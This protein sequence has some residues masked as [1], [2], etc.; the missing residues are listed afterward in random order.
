MTIIIPLFNVSDSN[1]SLDNISKAIKKKGFNKCLKKY[2]IRKCNRALEKL[3]FD[4]LFSD[5]RRTS[6]FGD[7]STIVGISWN[8]GP[9]GPWALGCEFKGNDLSKVRSKGEECSGKCKE[10]DGCTHYNWTKFNGG[11]CWMKRGSATQSDA[12]KSLSGNVCGFLSKEISWNDGGDGPWAMG[13]EFKGNDLSNVRSKGE[14]CSGRCKSTKGC[15]HYNW[16]NENGGTC[17]MKQGSIS[18]SNA[19]NSL[20]NNVCGILNMEISWNDGPDGPW[21][22][23]CDFNGNDLSNVRSE[24]EECSGKCKL[25]KG[26]THYTW[27]NFNDGTCWMKQGSI[28]Q[29]NAFKAE[30]E[31]N[32]VCGILDTNN[33]SIKWRDGPDGQEAFK[34]NFSGNDLSNVE[35][36]DYECSGECIATKGCTHYTWNNENGGTCRMKKGPISQS[37]ATFVEFDVDGLTCGIISHNASKGILFTKLNH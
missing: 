22:L 36:K 30:D 2:S 21:A 32:F 19:I 25:T 24:G 37:D 13:C 23:G 18:Q 33:T 4:Y 17:W 27:S 7:E 34:C 20:S 31:N 10:T 14:E 35:S 16:T 29:S 3:L 1:E 6:S 8:N 26:C 28:S 15:T 11:T 5:S 12:K 9:D